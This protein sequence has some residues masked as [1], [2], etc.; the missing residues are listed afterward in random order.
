MS[1]QLNVHYTMQY[2]KVMIL[3]VINVII[4]VVESYVCYNTIA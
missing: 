1:A 4:V 2:S 3:H